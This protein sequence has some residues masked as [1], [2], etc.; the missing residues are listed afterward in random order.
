MGT[1][2]LM[3]RVTELKE[4]ASLAVFYLVS[5]S[6]GVIL[7]ASHGS[8][9]ELVEILFGDEAL[10]QDLLDAIQDA[11][12]RDLANYDHANALIALR[13]RRSQLS[14]REEQVLKLVTAGMLNKQIAYELHLSEITVKIHRGQAMRKM[15]A[16]SLADFVLKAEALGVK[17]ALGAP[18]FVTMRTS[19]RV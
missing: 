19:P 18:S 13:E 16:R 15:R 3:S 10:L 12:A 8:S 4:D 6:L 7:V 17:A 5:L 2:W 14:I 11:M 1:A 9:H